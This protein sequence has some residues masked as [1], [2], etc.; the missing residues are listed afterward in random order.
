MDNE[1]LRTTNAEL[2]LKLRESE[3]KAEE[4]MKQ[5][6]N[7]DAIIDIDKKYK[8]KLEEMELKSLKDNATI[9][10][11]ENK[12]YERDET[13]RKKDKMIQ[14]MME[15]GNSYVNKKSNNPLAFG[16]IA[17]K[18]SGFGNIAMKDSGFGNNNQSDLGGHEN[19]NI[20]NQILKKNIEN[21]K[22][23]AQRMSEKLRQKDEEILD[24]EEK[25][26]DQ[27]QIRVRV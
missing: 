5:M 16:N 23:T 22:E 8:D 20:D 2:V 19:R 24:L 11:L 26:Q 27:K 14:D 21:L 15:N 9:M 7:P 17:M 1:K 13:M 6:D 12:L 4:L 18:E 10:K 25:L 3:K